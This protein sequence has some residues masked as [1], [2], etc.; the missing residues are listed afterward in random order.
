MSKAIRFVRG[1]WPRVV[2]ALGMGGLVVAAMVWA[3]E[4]YHA[5]I[6]GLVTAVAAWLRVGGAS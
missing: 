1:E 5:P 6:A 4:A 3:P 2:L